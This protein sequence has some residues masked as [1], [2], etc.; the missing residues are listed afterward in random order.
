M[1]KRSLLAITLISA[2]SVAP[3]SVFAAADQKGDR[4]AAD[5]AAD[6]NPSRFGKGPAD[7]AF[8]AYQRGL[9]VTALNLA[10]P[11][12]KEGDAPSQT[13]V[14][15]IYSRGLGV[16]VNLPEAAKWYGEAAK[17]GVPEAQFRYGV[18]LLEGRHVQKDMVKGEELMKLA[19]ESNNPLAQFNYAQLLLKAG[20]SEVGADK[21]YP[22]FLKAAETGLP[23]AQYAVSQ[24]LATGAPSVPKNDVKA[25]EYL[26]KAAIKGY[27][28]AQLDL[29]TWMVEG[30]GGKRDYD[31]GFK[32]MMRAARGGNVAAQARLA[33]LY[34]MGLGVEG[35]SIEAAAWY[36]V[37]K[38]A[39]L[40]DD[41]LES[42]MDGLTEGET[43]EAISRANKLR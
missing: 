30:R 38:R 4:P 29:A 16:P 8:G 43:S 14:A 20:P 19:A 33:K 12:A 42:H 41:D 25:R 37:A 11:K 40:V 39:G 26:E 6:V 34:I 21:A 17:Q 23:D 2:L 36:I 15:E 32:W 31:T 1:L 10:L 22:W 24:I 28:T 5:S 13:L 9:Y 3:S 7:E 35:D 18:M 27:D